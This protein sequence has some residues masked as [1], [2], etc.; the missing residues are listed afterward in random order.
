LKG[1]QITACTVL[2]LPINRTKNFSETQW[3][4]WPLN[5]INTH[6]LSTCTAQ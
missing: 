2:L 6:V 5:K 4:K 3:H 1:E